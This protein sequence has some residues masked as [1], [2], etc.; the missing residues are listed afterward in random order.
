MRNNMENN[1]EIFLWATFCHAYNLCIPAN[2]AVEQYS[3]NKMSVEIPGPET[4][5]KKMQ[6]AR[7]N[8]VFTQYTIAG[9]TRTRL[10][11]GVDGMPILLLHGEIP[12]EEVVLTAILE[13]YYV[14]VRD[15]EES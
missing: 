10:S 14:G 7:D 8:A 9:I 2:V 13:A 3:G 5:I 11:F 4:P 6:L 1:R 12:F 15:G